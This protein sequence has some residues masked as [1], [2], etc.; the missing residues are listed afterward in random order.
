[1]HALLQD[2][3][4]AAR[5]LRRSPLFTTTAVLALGL[6]IAANTAIF[7]LIDALLLRPMPGVNRPNELVVFERR[8]AGQLLGN[9]SYPDYLDY[10]GQLR[11]FSGLA[12]EADARV[13][14]TAGGASERAAAALVSGNYFAVLGARPAAGRLLSAADEIDGGPA[15]AVI[16]HTFW[17]RAFAGDPRAVGS[18]VR[19][20]GQAFTVVGVAPPKLLGTRTQFQPDVWLSITQQPAAMP[21]MSP[22]TLN[23]RASGWLRIFGRLQAGTHLAAAQAEVTTVASRLARAYPATN[24]T[25]TVTLVPGL[26][27]DSDDRAEMGRLLGLLLTCVGL[28][29]LIACANVANLLLARAVARRREVAV[30]VAMGA[31]SARLVRMFLVEGALLAACA[32]LLGTLLA[33]V[34]AQLAVSANQDAYTMRGVDVQLDLRVLAFVLALTFISGLLFAMA[35]ARRAARVDLVASLKDGSAGAGR[36][37]SRLRGVLIAAQ[38]ALSLVLL[39]GAGTGIATLW[40]ALGANPVAHPEEVLLG[41]LDLDVQ[42]YSPDKAMLFYQAL[43]DRVRALPGVGS[44]SLGSTIP[45]E[46]F[47]ARRAIFRAGEE[48]P[49]KDFPGREFEMGLR[50]DTAAIAPGFLRTLGI[51]L[52]AGREFGERDRADSLRVGM[53]NERL[54]QRFWPGKNPIGE[55]VAAPEFSGP[56]R[57]PVTI[58]GVMQDAAVRSLAGEVT[59]QLY[60]PIAQEPDGRATLIVRSNAGAARMSGALRDAVAGLDA[61]VPLFAVKSMPEH[62][63]ASL[64]RQRMAA[65]LLGVFGALAVALASMGIYGVAAHSVSQRTR[66]IGI[67]MA[68]GA[69]REHIS[70]LVIREG[71]A[72]VLA[73]AAAGL[74]T[75]LLATQA[76]QKGIPGVRP[77]DPWILAAAVALLGAVSL[78]ASY[79][80]ARRA[81]RLDPMVALRW[82]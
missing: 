37:R 44:A 70:G 64:W 56:A 36:S 79:L 33:P 60:L 55:R 9:M 78:L 25:R 8:Q 80:P 73:G 19:L 65:G 23:N 72:W 20:N 71:M 69:R 50:V 6:G 18:A 31:G 76:M 40:Q 42:G 54:A 13:S 22:G 16:S 28:L 63:A 62:I 7:S 68:I 58:V 11:S 21:R 34:V 17:K 26:G 4:F 2:A 5:R 1:M 32:G 47:F 49:L 14:F 41:S 53:V 3:R 48:P 29:Q 81:A 35:P 10:R 38:I 61:S 51:P 77:F 30:R 43:L 52:I 57:P 74:P 46:E 15:V 66:E 75:A 24:H 67:R 39:A 12:A 82:E 27:L 45:P 59:M